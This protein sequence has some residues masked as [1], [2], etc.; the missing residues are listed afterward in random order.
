[1]ETNDPAPNNTPPIV[2][3]ILV[4]VFL[5]IMYYGATMVYGVLGLVLH[6]FIV[7]IL[8]FAIMAVVGVLLWSFLASPR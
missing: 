3:F 4:S 5:V 1:M 7:A 8:G 6:P 2:G